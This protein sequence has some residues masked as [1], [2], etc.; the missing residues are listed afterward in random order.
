MKA[1]GYSHRRT[2]VRRRVLFSVSRLHHLQLLHPRLR[3]MALPTC[4]CSVLSSHSPKIFRSAPPSPHPRISPSS[5]PPDFHAPLAFPVH[6]LL[7]L[8]YLHLP[9]PPRGACYLPITLYHLRVLGAALDDPPHLLTPPAHPVSAPPTSA[10]SS[11]MRV[12]EVASPH[13]PSC[14]H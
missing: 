14:F 11:P 8:P 12:E 10:L 4:P 13:S 7:S 3:S 1:G 5:T 6:C 2:K 9:L